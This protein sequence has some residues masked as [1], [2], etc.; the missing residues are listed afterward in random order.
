MERRINGRLLLLPLN[1]LTKTLLPA[2]FQRKSLYWA[3]FTASFL[4]LAVVREPVLAAGDTCVYKPSR[5]VQAIINGKS[6]TVEIDNKTGNWFY[7]PANW[8]NCSGAFPGPH[9]DAV[10][11]A[12]LTVWTGQSF[13]IDKNFSFLIPAVGYNSV[14]KL[15]LEKGASLVPG[16]K[17][18]MKSDL[19]LF[20][21]SVET[22]IDGGKLA[23][24]IPLRLPGKVT[25][26]NGGSIDASVGGSLIN[27]DVAFSGDPA[28]LNLGKVIVEEKLGGGYGTYSL[29]STMPSPIAIQS[30]QF[31][32]ATLKLLGG[33]FYASQI[34]IG[35]NAVLEVAGTADVAAGFLHNRGKL[36]LKDQAHGRPGELLNFG[37]VQLSPNSQ[38]IADRFQLEPSSQFISYGALGVWGLL[39][40]KRGAELSQ[41]AGPMVIIP[42]TNDKIWDLKFASDKIVLNNLTIAENSGNAQYNLVSDGAPAAITI[43]GKLIFSGKNRVTVSNSL[44]LMVTGDVENDGQLAVRNNARLVSEGRIRNTG[45]LAVDAA[46]GGVVRET[47]KVVLTDLIG[48]PL[49][50][51]VILPKVIFVTVT[52]GSRNFDGSK[53]E[54]VQ[55]AVYS[56]KISNGAGWD[57]EKVTLTETG[58]ATG[59][60]RSADQLVAAALPLPGDKPVSSDKI[61]SAKPQYDAYFRSVYQDPND[62]W[63]GGISPE[64]KWESPNK[65]DLVPD[66]VIGAIDG[67]G[68][69]TIRYSVVNQGAGPAKPFAAQVSVEGDLGQAVAAP[70]LEAGSILAG[71]RREY[72][73]MISS[74]SLQAVGQSVKLTVAVD[75]NNDVDEVDENNNSKTVLF[76][77]QIDVLDVRVKRLTKKSQNKNKKA[78]Y[79]GMEASFIVKNNGATA[80]A[81]MMIEVEL[82]GNDNGKYTNKIYKLSQASIPAQETRSLKFVFPPADLLAL[83]KFL[84]LSIKITESAP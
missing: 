68:D 40:I 63:Q 57:E 2:V 58:P 30:L 42:P 56:D 38:L 35:S 28:G 74:S 32:K 77:S 60:F 73:A 11:P 67:N 26:K 51:T 61:I 64:V 7:D 79:N 82:S 47:P 18:Y 48:A 5:T 54:S 53:I 3:I 14:R 71:D 34:E 83:K 66:S 12:G 8:I 62:M 23:L 36:F 15:V 4:F 6:S 9:D 22:V 1:M 33:K 81:P 24:G 78:A 49:G 41:P 80:S 13:Y 55:A 69:L 27:R 39:D 16:D 52:D 50:D 10:I 76:V 46:S 59:V 31:N 17:R 25:V 37:F 75:I 29:V 84:G 20:E 21:V 44:A 19:D 45:R 70:V 43:K 72:A 65:V